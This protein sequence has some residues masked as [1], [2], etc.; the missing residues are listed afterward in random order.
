[1]DLIPP[2]YDELM[3]EISRLR[4]SNKAMAR[5]IAAECSDPNGTIWD[6]AKEL[7]EELSRLRADMAEMRLCA[8]RL[9]VAAS[10]QQYTVSSMGWRAQDGITSS[11]AGARKEQFDEVAGATKD[12]EE[13]LNAQFPSQLQHRGPYAEL[14]AELERLKCELAKIRSLCVNAVNRLVCLD[15]DDTDS[16]ADELECVVR[17]LRFRETAGCVEEKKRCGGSDISGENSQC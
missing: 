6:H 12:V 15:L 11:V 7:Q 17:M 4:E 2:T 5:M 16:C 13:V 14:R 9:Y 3:A 1:M 10:E 8:D